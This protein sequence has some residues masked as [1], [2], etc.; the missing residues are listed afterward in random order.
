[1]FVFRFRP[2]A[3]CGGLFLEAPSSRIGLLLAG[4]LPA[5]GWRR[6]SPPNNAVPRLA[7]GINFSWLAPHAFGR[8]RLGVNAYPLAWDC[9]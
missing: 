7:F 6:W 1:M 5:R 2:P 8:G 9:G 4:V 3:T